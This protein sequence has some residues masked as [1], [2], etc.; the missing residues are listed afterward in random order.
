MARY[1]TRIQTLM[2]VDQAFDFMADLR[3]FEQWDP[4]VA[5]SRQVRGEGPG[6]D[7]AYRVIASNVELIYYTQVFERPHRLVAEANTERLRS[8]DV[9]TVEDAGSGSIVTYDARLELKG[10]Y[11]VFDP[12]LGLLFRR[13]GKRADA[14]LQKALNGIKV[15]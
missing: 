14:G 1:K 8:F 6:P 5:S 12:L 3:N 13:I 9:I 15:A 10:A 7:A 11:C 4:G 2:A